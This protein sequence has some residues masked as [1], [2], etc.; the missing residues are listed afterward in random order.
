LW[1]E[2]VV[3]QLP[4]EILAVHLASLPLANPSEVRKLG[5]KKTAGMGREGN[6]ELFQIVDL[7]LLVGKRESDRDRS[8][9]RS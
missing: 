7:E 3:G 4:E 9:E 8:A 5:I 2:L 1:K 6:E